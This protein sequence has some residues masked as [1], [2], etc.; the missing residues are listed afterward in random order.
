[1]KLISQF[2]IIGLLSSF[3]LAGC[4]PVETS[5]PMTIQVLAMNDFHGALLPPNK[6]ETGGIAHM[7]TLINELRVANPNTIVVGSGD[8]VGASPLLSAMFND[9]PTIEAL[10]AIGMEASVVGNHEFDK[11]KAELLRKQNG[12]CHPTSGCFNN[13]P[14]NGAQFKYLAANVID[15]DTNKSLFPEYYIKNFDGVDIAFIG[16]VLE[17]A[18]VIISPSGTRGLT[19]ENEAVTINRIVKELQAKGIHNIGILL[20]E[21]ATQT[22]PS[23]DDI[24]SCSGISGKAI[25]IVS[26]LDQEVDFVLSGHTHKYYNCVINDIPLVS[27]QSNGVILSQVLLS[28]DKQNKEIMDVK[29]N[30]ILVDNQKYA[31]DEKLTALIEEYQVKA[32]QVSSQVVGQLAEDLN[33]NLT[34]HGDSLLGRVIADGQLYV[35]AEPGQGDAQIAFINSGGIRAPLAGGEVTYNDIYTVQPF[36]NMVVTKTLTG[37]QLKNL[38]EQQW[39][40]VRPQVMP[41]ST[42]FYYEWDD[43]QPAGSK[44]IVSSMKLNGVPL[45]MNGKYRVA[46]NEFLAEGGSYFTEFSKGTDPV[47]SLVDNESIVKYFMDNSPIS[48]PTDIRVRKVQ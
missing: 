15:T 11:G 43:S 35:A 28:V 6:G 40:R 34:T 3:M 37:Q 45:D 18:P 21:G 5:E 4:K 8:L 30:N 44:V 13:K 2:C 7:A 27:G 33:K 9:E 14:F 23:K 29:V 16:V 20:H 1:M 19:F 32:E 39:D 25:D 41:V 36:S 38:L 46:A 42:G 26:Q 10:S 48:T 17:G 22:E 31:A 24:N 12:R 47:Y